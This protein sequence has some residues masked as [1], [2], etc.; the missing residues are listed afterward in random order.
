ME[1]YQYAQGEVLYL[2]E[3]AEIF[4]T[5]K[6]DELLHHCWNDLKAQL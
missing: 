6:D 5:G 1:I 3:I 2:T 4:S